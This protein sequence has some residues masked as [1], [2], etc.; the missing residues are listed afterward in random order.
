MI[1][2]FDKSVLYDYAHVWYLVWYVLWQNINNLL[3]NLIPRKLYTR[4]MLGGDMFF[5]NKRKNRNLNSQIRCLLLADI[6]YIYLSSS[7]CGK[8]I[9]R[10]YVKD[11]HNYDSLERNTPAFIASLRKR[12]KYE[13]IS[14]W[15][16]SIFTSKVS[17]FDY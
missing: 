12:F 9:S 14:L 5:F 3:K 7:I 8:K 10:S 6:M 15:C 1:F 2:Q 11:V 16:C 13:R 4:S 17:N